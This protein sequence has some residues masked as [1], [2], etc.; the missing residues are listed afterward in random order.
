MHRTLNSTFLAVAITGASLGA[1]AAGVDAPLL[2]AARKA[3]PA[4]IETLKNMVMIESGSSDAAGLARMADYTEGGS[5]RSGWRP[6][7]SAGPPVRAA[8]SSAA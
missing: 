8:S 5:K 6:S 2:E 7:A 4:V 1:A 3:E